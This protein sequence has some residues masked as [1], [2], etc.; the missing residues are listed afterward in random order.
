MATFVAVLPAALPGCASTPEGVLATT[1]PADLTLLLAPATT[2]AVG[3]VELATDGEAVPNVAVQGNDA[4]MSNARTPTAHASTH[5]NA[6]TDEISVAALSGQLADPQPPII[7]AG[8]TQAVAGNDARLT[9]ARTPLAHATS[10]KSGGSDAIK[11]DELA[12]PTDVT[13]LNA[14]LTAHG[15]LQ[16]LPGGTTTFL[17][18]DGAF[19]TPA[20]G[21]GNTLYARGSFTVA[22]GNFDLMCKRL[23][24]TGSQ[25]ATL[26]GTARLRIT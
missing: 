4:R 13:T 20:G 5:Q 2:T 6:G 16:K 22:T 10:H 24:L 26:Q 17:R 14:S 7:G 15:L 12:A 11:L 8:A 19:A 1:T 3:V 25:R 9:D 21:A 23:Q 18:A